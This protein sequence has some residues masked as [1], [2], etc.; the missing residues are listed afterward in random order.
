MSLTVRAPQQYM[1][2]VGQRLTRTTSDTLVNRSKYEEV[3]AGPIRNGRGRTRAGVGRPQVRQA[4]D[5]KGV[6]MV[7]RRRRVALHA[8]LRQT[9]RGHLLCKGDLT[10]LHRCSADVAVR[11]ARRLP[12]A[13]RCKSIQHLR[14]RWHAV[15]GVS[16]CSACRLAHVIA[17]ICAQCAASGAPRPAAPS[18]LFCKNCYKLLHSWE[19]GRVQPAWEAHVAV[20][21]VQSSR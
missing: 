11:L 15:L 2:R 18:I 17:C 6:H 10:V 5:A 13:C 21:C 16:Q 3:Y 7:L 12:S 4:Q 1:Q 9:G 19:W 8:P 20:P 14:L